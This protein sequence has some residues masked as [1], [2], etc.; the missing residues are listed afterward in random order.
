MAQ[1]NRHV[2]RKATLEVNGAGT[3]DAFRF[4]QEA[5]TWAHDRLLPELELAFASLPDMAT[6]VILDRLEIEVDASDAAH[7]GSEILPRLKV[8]LAAALIKGLMEGGQGKGGERLPADRSIFRKLAHYLEHGVLPWNLEAA[9]PEAFE[10]E[11]NSWLASDGSRE[12]AAELAGLFRQPSI[13]TRFL[14]TFRP[15]LILQVLIRIFRM[16]SGLSK[17]WAKD[18][19]LLPLTASTRAPAAPISEVSASSFP[20]ALLQEILGALSHN[21]RLFEFALEEEIIQAY[22][23]RMILENGLAVDTLKALPFASSAFTISRERIFRQ[24]PGPRAFAPPSEAALPVA[25]A[26]Q[27]ATPSARLPDPG[28]AAVSASR[29]KD[30]EPAVDPAVEGIYIHNAGLILLAPFLTMLFER[31]DLAKSG[32]MKDAGTAMALQ[33]YLVTGQEGPVEFLVALPKVLCGW[34][35]ENNIALP[36]NLDDS[37]KLEA[38]QLLESVIGHWGILKN[39]SVEGL[40]ES[41]LQRQGKL[42]RTAKGDWLLQVEQRAYDM[43]LQQL[44]WS[45]NL[46]RLPWMNNVLRTEWVE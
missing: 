18:A 45:F 25:P 12:M 15:S 13:R 43:L 36:G 1:G 33:H 3:V 5:V 17:E 9:D 41:F 16:P 2:I 29:P 6:H 26:A 28:P 23:G 10:A 4:Q 24:V 40:R 37:M 44:P 35:L 19:A 32:E 7:W 14:Q 27:G 22:L 46:I 42:S 31:L 8:E 11:I 34:P 21:P 30:I 38:G 20:A 39:T